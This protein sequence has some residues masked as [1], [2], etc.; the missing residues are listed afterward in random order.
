MTDSEW[1]R[2]DT[3]IW[4]RTSDHAVVLPRDLDEPLV[5]SGAAAWAWD[6]LVVPTTLNEMTDVLAKACGVEPEVVR[7]G[8]DEVL[9]ALSSCGAIHD[10]PMER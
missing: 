10:Q 1:R 6:L 4:R 5:L 3:T 8:L 9:D 2:S 7:R